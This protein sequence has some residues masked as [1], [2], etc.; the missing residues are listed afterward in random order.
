MSYGRTPLSD[1]A[2]RNCDHARRICLTGCEHLVPSCVQR[3]K[4]GCVR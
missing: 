4:A 2:A 1:A 3:R